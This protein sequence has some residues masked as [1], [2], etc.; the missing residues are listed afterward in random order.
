MSLVKIALTLVASLICVALTGCVP[1]VSG[2]TPRPLASS[3]A[4]APIFA[5]DEEALAAATK[6]YA[7]YLTM[8]DRVAQEGGVGVDRLAPFVTNSYLKKQKA[9]FSKLGSDNHRIVGHTKFREARLQRF[10]VSGM[11]TQIEI[12]VCVDVSDV[13]VLDNSRT[14]VTPSDRPN[15]YPIVIGLTRSTGSHAL[16]LNSSDLWEGAN[17]C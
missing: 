7:D 5:T 13:R 6:A 15:E 3:S 17:F 11:S 2:A 16:L 9:S 8:S 12:Y 4:A 1:P 14:D 10:Q